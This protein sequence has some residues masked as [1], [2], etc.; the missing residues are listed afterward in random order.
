MK[1]RK[2][3]EIALVFTSLL[4]H[5]TL[6]AYAQYSLVQ[7]G[8]STNNSGYAFEVALQGNFAYLGNST[9][10]RIFDV[11]DPTN[12]ITVG[13]TNVDASQVLVSGNRAYL[14]S[15]GM[16]V[17]KIFD[18]SN[19]INPVF[20]GQATNSDVSVRAVSGDLAFLLGDYAGLRIYDVS[21][22]T[23]PFSVSYTYL[24]PY[25]YD[26]AVAGEYAYVSGNFIYP[27]PKRLI[28]VFNIANPT[29][30]VRVGELAVTNNGSYYGLIK[31]SENYA[32]MGGGS[33]GFGGLWIYD[34][35]NPTNLV[36]VGYTKTTIPNPRG[37]A[38]SGNLVYL[39]QG[40]LQVFDVSNPANPVLAGQ[41]TLGPGLDVQDVAASGNHVFVA[42]RLK[43]LTILLLVP[44][45]S[46]AVTN[47]NFVSVSW[48]VP[49]INNFVLQQNSDLGAASWTDVTNAPVVVSNRNQLALPMSANSTL[50]RLRSP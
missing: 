26:V 34:I 37:M 9:S 13:I 4:L 38:I 20:L 33:N 16:N 41:P 31:L 40:L 5:V 3:R 28:Q 8:N 7:I 1:I 44:Q 32:Y 11:S 22:P 42:N 17:M 35:S 45:L 23:M 46:L 47:A 50:Y 25:G 39:A 14:H 27:A 12:P 24:G 10:F 18:I 48:P 30:P 6:P 15:G 43:G 19:P 21:N 29:N 36:A 2:H 49:P